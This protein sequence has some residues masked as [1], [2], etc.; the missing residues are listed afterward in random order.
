MQIPCTDHLNFNDLIYP[1]M[2]ISGHSYKTV[3]SMLRAAEN[4]SMS[5]IDL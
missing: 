2:L 3:I 4:S 1:S 5:A